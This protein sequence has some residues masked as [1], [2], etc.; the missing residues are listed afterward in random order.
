[1]GGLPST[2]Y[3]VHP[4]IY[5]PPNHS[6]GIKVNQIF[7]TDDEELYDLPL[8]EI[9]A[10]WF[11]HVLLNC[12]PF[13]KGD[14]S[15]LQK[16]SNSRNARFRITYRHSRTQ[17]RHNTVIHAGGNIRA[18]FLSFFL[19]CHQCGLWCCFFIIFQLG[20]NS[21]CK[22]KHISLNLWGFVQFL[23]LVTRGVLEWLFYLI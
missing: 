9:G 2:W 11:V 7:S 22:P 15:S 5:D 14:N 16:L 23:W 10:G 13:E 17:K 20:S 6:G 19:W 8:G 12:S 4:T 1:M 21:I 3:P 18:I